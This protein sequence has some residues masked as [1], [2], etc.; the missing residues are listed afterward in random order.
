[1]NIGSSSQSSEDNA[2]STTNVLANR[3]TIADREMVIR[4]RE[5][6]IPA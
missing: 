1:M 3:K 2:H 5:P 4:Q 6:E